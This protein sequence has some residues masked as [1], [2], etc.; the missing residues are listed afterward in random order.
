[1]R[2]WRLDDNGA[3]GR[4]LLLVDDEPSIWGSV[5]CLLETQGFDVTD[6]GS[7]AEA[8]RLTLEAEIYADRERRTVT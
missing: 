5:K 1:M 6:A 3:G 7:S 8:L 4:R 2:D